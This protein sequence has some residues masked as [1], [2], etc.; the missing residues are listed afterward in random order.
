M[1]FSRASVFFYALIELT[2]L[3]ENPA[4]LRKKLEPFGR[5]LPAVRPPQKN[6]CRLAKPQIS[7]RARPPESPRPPRLYRL[8]R[9]IPLSFVRLAT[10]TRSVI[11]RV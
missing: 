8:V 7:P 4:Y 9:R 5:D 2:G 1:L 10:F 11:Q 3:I 6:H